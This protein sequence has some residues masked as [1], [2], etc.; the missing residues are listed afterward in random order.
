MVDDE[1]E[2]RRRNADRGGRRRHAHVTCG[3]ELGSRAEC[4]AV[5]VGDGD[6]LRIDEAVQ[7]RLQGVLELVLGDAGEIRPRTE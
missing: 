2:S 4:M 3:H 5:D 1:A 6:E 7:H